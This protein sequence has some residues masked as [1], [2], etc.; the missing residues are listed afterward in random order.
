MKRPETIAKR[1]CEL[2]L[3]RL[4]LEDQV[5]EIRDEE[6]KLMETG[7]AAF[8]ARKAPQVDVDGFGKVTLVKQPIATVQDWEKVYRY[9]AEHP[10][11]GVVHK[12]VSATAVEKLAFEKV[13]V[14]GVV[15]DHK[16]AL[17]VNVRAGR[18][19]A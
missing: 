1:L 14:P 12:R 7:V 13:A 16:Y 18:K 4:A 15:L 3:R 9:A 17:T 8:R 10:D 2:A 5:K 6:A 11:S 19:K